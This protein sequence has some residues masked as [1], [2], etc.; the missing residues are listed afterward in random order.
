MSLRV[1]SW[2]KCFFVY[3]VYFVVKKGNRAEEYIKKLMNQNPSK[4][5]VFKEIEG[6]LAKNKVLEAIEQLRG[7]PEYRR[8]AIRLSRQY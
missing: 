7:L 2:F 1:P 3:F 8:E 5:T 4:E 6:L